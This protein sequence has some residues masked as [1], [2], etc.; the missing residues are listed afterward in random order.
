MS[1]LFDASLLTFQ[2]RSYGSFF[3]LLA[4]ILLLPQNGKIF[5]T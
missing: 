2:S 3:W 5:E 1:A 4:R